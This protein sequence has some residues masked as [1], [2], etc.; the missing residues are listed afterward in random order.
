MQDKLIQCFG[1]KQ[2]SCM[3]VEVGRSFRDDPNT[4][5]RRRAGFETTRSKQAPFPFKSEVTVDV[6]ASAGD[7]LWK[8]LVGTGDDKPIKIRTVQL[9]F[10]GLMA[11]EGGQKTIEGFFKTGDHK[12]SREFDGTED[13]QSND[14]RA[15]STATIGDLVDGGISF[16]C[17][18]CSRR[19]SL[20]NNAVPE[21]FQGDSGDIEALE[22]LKMEHADFHFAQDLA[23]ITPNSGQVQFPSSKR[24]KPMDSSASGIARYFPQK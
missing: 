11:A 15:E 17:P 6:V 24:K 9:G 19:I 14:T 13:P 1:P 12:R 5:R 20:A 16:T 3:P 8:E 22:K 4:R 21:G 7:R 2:L 23:R 18:R 10:T